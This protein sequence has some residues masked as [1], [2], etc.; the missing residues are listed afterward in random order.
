MIALDNP[1]AG[2]SKTVQFNRCAYL[3]SVFYV[4]VEGID[5]EFLDH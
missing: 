4:V 2:S 5:L 1:L 3:L